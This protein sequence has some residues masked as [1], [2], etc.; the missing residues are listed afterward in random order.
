MHR[1]GVTVEGIQRQQVEVLRRLAFQGQ[2]RVPEHHIHLPLAVREVSER[3]V[4]QLQHV[5]VYLIKTQVIPRLAIRGQRA[6]AQADQA[7]PPTPRR[8]RAQCT[9]HAA[10]LIVVSRRP[11]RAHWVKELQAVLGASVRKLKIGRVCFAGIMPGQCQHP[12]EVPQPA[13]RHIGE[14]VGLH[15]KRDAQR[16]HPHCPQSAH[17]PAQPGEPPRDRAPKANGQE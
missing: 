6:G 4:G 17:R 2:T 15:P 14:P 10:S 11:G 9:P 5:R 12:I 16:C 1:D 13:D 7:D 8:Q 3:R